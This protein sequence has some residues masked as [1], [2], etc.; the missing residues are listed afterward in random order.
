MKINQGNTVG[1]RIG[2]VNYLEA[3]KMSENKSNSDLWYPP[4]SYALVFRR[5]KDS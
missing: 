5:L 2:L 4:I 3:L 1:Y